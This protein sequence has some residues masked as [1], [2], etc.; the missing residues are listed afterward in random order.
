MAVIHVTDR[1]G[2][3]HRLDAKRARVLM[4]V[5]RDEGMGIDAI[6][7]GQCACATCHCYIDPDRFK[8]LPEGDEY[9]Q[10]LLSYLD[11]YDAER[12]RLTCQIE[13]SEELDGLA[14]TVAPE[15]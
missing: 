10:E 4:E 11:G 7:G 13:V 8:K 9:E 12:S 2:N 14:L 5:L 6:C 15:E 1:D 3:Q